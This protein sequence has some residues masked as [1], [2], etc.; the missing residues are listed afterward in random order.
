MASNPMQRK[1]RNSFL[2]GI[3]TMLLIVIV[4]G[5]LVFF[6]VV[7]PMNDRKKAEEE[8]R[9]V[10][11]W[12]YVLS[13]DVKSGE[14]ITPAMLTEIQL[15]E[16]LIPAGYVDPIL[17]Q[18]MQ[19][20]DEYVNMLYCVYQENEIDKTKKQVLYMIVSDNQ[21]YK[22]IDTKTEHKDYVL[23]E[24][25]D[26]GYYKTIRNGNEKEYFKLI[27]T[28]TV[29]KVDLKANTILTTSVIAKS[30]EISTDSLRYVEYNMITIPVTLNIGDYIDIRL[31]LPN[32]QDLIVVSKKR[33]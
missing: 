8:Q 33:N 19:L 2:F 23:V 16:K 22:T 17:L 15:Y 1:V 10:E 29:A 3:L 6:L 11:T 9:G 21:L 13:Q 7:K 20:Q 28:P 25:D 27:N 14:I 30:D 5:L 32:G 4:I 26:T 24:K 12:T 18:T 31:R